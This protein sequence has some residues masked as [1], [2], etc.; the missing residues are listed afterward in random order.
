MSREGFSSGLHRSSKTDPRLLL[1]G[2]VK[3]IRIR[4]RV[5]SRRVRVAAML[6]W[7]L[8]TLDGTVQ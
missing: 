6:G 7:K 1:H 4:E 3:N 2:Q 8:L 5:L